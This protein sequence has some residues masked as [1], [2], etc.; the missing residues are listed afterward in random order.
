MA[1]GPHTLGKILRG[2]AFSFELKNSSY[3][4]AGTRAPNKKNG[5]R[6]TSF[7]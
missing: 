7:G 1:F 5:A 2:F 3:R 6:V 4:P